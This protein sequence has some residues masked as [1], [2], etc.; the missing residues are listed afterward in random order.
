MHV[1]NDLVLDAWSQRHITSVRALDQCA[2]H[3]LST[4]IC[5]PPA[6]ARVS[7]ASGNAW[8]FAQSQTTRAASC[9][10]RDHARVSMWDG[11]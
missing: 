10:S 4:L 6:W 9:V 8:S 5:A 11:G 1:T 7:P 3:H 2:F